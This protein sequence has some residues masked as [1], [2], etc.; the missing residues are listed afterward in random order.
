MVQIMAREYEALT[1]ELHGQAREN[2]QLRTNMAN[3]EHVLMT[4]REHLQLARNEEVIAAGEIVN[5][6][7]TGFQEQQHLRDRLGEEEEFRSMAVQR[8]RDAEEQL[9]Q[10]EDSARQTLPTMHGELNELRRALKLQ[11]DAQARTR[12]ELEAARLAYQG[13]R[14]AS[15]SMPM[16]SRTTDSGWE[17]MSRDRVQVFPI[18]ADIRSPE[19]RTPSHRSS[20]I[21]EVFDFAG[22]SQPT[23]SLVT[24]ETAPER[25]APRVEDQAHERLA[26]CATSSASSPEKDTTT[27][28]DARVTHVTRYD[29]EIFFLIYQCHQRCQL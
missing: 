17:Y 23:P 27:S 4:T 26:Q 15:S 11:E 6:R 25:F 9:R 12:S 28:N 21:R 7:N 18:G 24:E 1:S 14:Q 8:M 3:S 16:S 19:V 5:I 20:V 2:L 10:V 29:G 22:T 13:I